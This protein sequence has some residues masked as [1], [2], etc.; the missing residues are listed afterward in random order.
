MTGTS[1][2]PKTI[3]QL[4]G[5]VAEPKRLDDALGDLDARLR[6]LPP[7]LFTHMPVGI[8][9]LDEAFGGGVTAQ[10]LIL[11]GGKQNVGKTAFLIQI[12]RNMA[13]WS[14]SQ[15]H[16]L[17][18][19]LISYE[20]DEWDLLARLLCIESYLVDPETPLDYHT[21]NQQIYQ[22][23]MEEQETGKP[24]EKFLDALMRRLPRSGLQA[25]TRL[26]VIAPHLELTHGSRRYMT[27]DAIQRI[28]AHKQVTEGLHYL[29]K[30]DY[31]QTMPPPVDLIRYEIRESD[32]V[33]L[34]NLDGLKDMAM[35]YWFP[36]FAVVAV[37][38]LALRQNRPIHVEDFLGPEKMQYS[39]DRCIVIN[40][41]LVTAEN[42][43]TT[44][45]AKSIRISLEKNRK[46]P[47]DIE[48]RHRYHGSAFFTELQG[49]AVDI[50]ESF[51]VARMRT[52]QGAHPL[53]ALSHV[54]LGHNRKGEST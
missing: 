44:V 42:A 24:V 13:V 30:L 23:K 3:L 10:D 27:T 35:R 38:T 19:W 15:G 43:S 7:V 14:Q 29:P 4:P 21:I 16:P 8:S 17:I 37:D 26:G 32:L 40:P 2:A 46:G 11:I 1:K 51:Q 36:V 20:H 9:W 48:Y 41:D 33:Y 28:I 34:Y 54:V 18:H 31:L 39:P 22:I 6:A 45:R 12:T 25:F 47:A 50:A 52:K 49:E 53:D 5:D